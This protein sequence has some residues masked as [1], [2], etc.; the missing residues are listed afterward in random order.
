MIL[1]ESKLKKKIKKNP[2]IKKI[3]FLFNFCNLI[4]YSLFKMRLGY[5]KIDELYDAVLTTHLLSYS[6][7]G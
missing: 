4:F 2:L 7:K 1:R 6:K 3:K 5:T